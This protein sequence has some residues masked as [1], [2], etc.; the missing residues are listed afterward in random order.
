MIEDSD[1]SFGDFASEEMIGDDILKNIEL[2]AC[3]IDK[4]INCNHNSALLFSQF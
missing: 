3:F 4:D 2:L 1:S